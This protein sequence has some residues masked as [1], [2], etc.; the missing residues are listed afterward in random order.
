MNVILRLVLPV[1]PQIM[2]LITPVL[3]ETLEEFLQDLYLKAKA[4]PNPVDDI[5]VGILAG[6]VG[7]E[8]RE[9]A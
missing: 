3:R 6:L 2:K 4:T 9:R 8:V 1:I 7:V 5:L